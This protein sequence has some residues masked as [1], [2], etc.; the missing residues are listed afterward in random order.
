MWLKR[1]NVSHLNSN[2]VLSLIAKRLNVPKSKFT[3]PGRYSVLRPTLPKVRPVGTANAAGVVRERSTFGTGCWNRPRRGIA[4]QVRTRTGAN[5]VA[6]AGVVAEG[7]AV[8]HAERRARL[9]DGDA[10][11]L[12]AAQERVLQSLAP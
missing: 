4:D 11:Y 6:D 12:P 7:R 9:R 8:G 5:A 3:R 1:L 10:R 2:P